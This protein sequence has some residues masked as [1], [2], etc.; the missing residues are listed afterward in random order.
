MLNG[1][2]KEEHPNTG[3][4]IT[5]NIFREEI[6]KILTMGRPVKYDPGAVATIELKMRRNHSIIVGATSIDDRVYML[7]LV[8][9]YL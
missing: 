9:S 1:S 7:K 8:D 3:K 6:T 2:K 4:E 5:D